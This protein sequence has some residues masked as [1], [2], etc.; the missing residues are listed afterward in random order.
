MVTPSSALHHHPPP[1]G[2]KMA[3]QGRPT[4]RTLTADQKHNMK[5]NA[6]KRPH[7]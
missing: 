2:T 4:K 6:H 1:P 7:V 5:Q 3:P